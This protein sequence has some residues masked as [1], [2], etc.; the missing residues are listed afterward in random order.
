[1]GWRLKKRPPVSE[2]EA[3]APGQ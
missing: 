3:I 1:L 2:P